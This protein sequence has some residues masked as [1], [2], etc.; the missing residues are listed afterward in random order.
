MAKKTGKGTRVKNLE[1]V[2]DLTKTI[3]EVTKKLGPDME[4]VSKSMKGMI[5]LATAYGEKLTDNKE[6]GLKY[7]EAEQNAANKLN[8]SPSTARRWA[9][10][11][12]L[13]FKAKSKYYRNNDNE[14]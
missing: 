10:R 5:D 1:E 2:K 4:G 3:T 14:G 7:S 8:V 6:K 13:K 11:I 12:G 9:D